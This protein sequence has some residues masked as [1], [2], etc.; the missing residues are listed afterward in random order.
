[1]Y[2][3]LNP[4]N[5]DMNDRRK[6]L[7]AS[8]VLGLGV[9]SGLSAACTSPKF[10]QK[11]IDR[12]LLASDKFR[13][14]PRLTISPDLVVK[15]T[16]GLRP[17]RKN[18]FRLEKEMLGNKTIIHNYGHGGSGWSLS[19]GTGNMAATLAE[20]TGEKKFAVMGCGVVGLTTARLLQMRGFDVTIYTKD[21]PPQVTSSKATGTWSP[22]YRLIEDEFLTTEFKERWKQ[23][24][25]FSF[26]TYQNLLGLGDIVTWI[27]NYVISNG[28]HQVAP[29]H[30]HELEIPGLLPEDKSLSPK[31]HPFNAA[32][33]NRQPTLVFNIPS[34]LT[35]HMN[36]F[37]AF[38]GSIRIQAF[39]SLE[40]I[41]ALPEK[42]V[43]NC[44][45]LGSYS[46][47]NDK[48]LTPVAG[49]LS[50]LIPQPDFNYRITT[51]E[52]YAIPRKDGIVL[53]GNALVGSWDETPSS[54]QTDKV[55]HA[56]MNV[57]SKFRV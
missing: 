49:Q 9:L 31:E 16:V 53:G 23:A 29:G 7:K 57:M 33:V 4:Y 5:L 37:L 55:V 45:G 27:D 42:C 8:G 17:F 52:A 24:T 13:K 41:D 1:M 25:L 34:Y 43:L 39:N 2:V 54:E 10:S 20:Q 36:D 19:W 35:K 6:F 40:E 14:F 56:L 50:F 11:F 47:F 32:Q 21:L 30:S 15:E 12:N 26:R 48:N 22:S 3:L 38:G 46:L 51:P 28:Q 18:G 44:T